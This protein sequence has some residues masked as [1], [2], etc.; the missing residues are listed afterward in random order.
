M[1]IALCGFTHSV[2]FG[3]IFGPV[4]LDS[5]RFAFVHSGQ[6]RVGSIRFDPDVL[7]DMLCCLFGLTPIFG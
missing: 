2:R 1:L 4:R 5:L 3:A 7:L 6:G